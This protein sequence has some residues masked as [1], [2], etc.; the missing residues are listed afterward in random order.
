MAKI[1]QQMVLQFDGQEFDLGAVEANVKKDWKD[2]GRKLT[3]IQTLD[4]YVKPREAKVY[5]V[6]NK[7]VEGKV[8][9]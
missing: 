8:D 9:L 4:I 7:E 5:Y 1:N 6:V 3:E 2:A